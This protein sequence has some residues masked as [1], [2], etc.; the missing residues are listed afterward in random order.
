MKALFSIATTPHSWGGIYID[1]LTLDPY[2]MMLSVKQ[3]GIQYHF[4]SLWCDLIWESTSISGAIV[5]RPNLYTNWWVKENCNSTILPIPREIWGGI[6]PSLRVFIRKWRPIGTGVRTH[7][8]QC[9]NPV[10]SPLRP[11]HSSLSKMYV[12]SSPEYLENRYKNNI[13]SQKNWRNY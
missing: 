7:F 10:R 9:H 8:L 4:L 11:G 6:I 2:I 1:P 13:S 12:Y 5:E 3:G